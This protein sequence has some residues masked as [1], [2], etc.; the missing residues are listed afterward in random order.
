MAVYVDGLC[1][2]L[3]FVL[4]RQNKGYLIDKTRFS[5]DLFETFVLFFFDNININ[6]FYDSQKTIKV[7]RK[8]HVLTSAGGVRLYASYRRRS[9]LG[10]AIPPR[11][12]RGCVPCIWRCKRYASI[13]K[14]QEMWL[15]MYTEQA[16]FLLCSRPRRLMAKFN[17]LANHLPSF[18][19]YLGCKQHNT[20][21]PGYNPPQPHLNFILP[22]A[23]INH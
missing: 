9:E 14:I 20:S 13:R 15:F 4:G 21:F 2:T 23:S 10:N 18:F 5:D 7:E 6:G 1:V 16:K 8:Q 22:F 11:W 12:S 17:E 3:G 19:I